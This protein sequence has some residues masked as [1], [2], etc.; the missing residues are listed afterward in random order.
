[1]KEFD[2]M[3]IIKR[4][5]GTIPGEYGLLVKSLVDIK[6][7]SRDKLD[8]VANGYYI[9]FYL[10][11]RAKELKMEDPRTRKELRIDEI[12]ENE[13][14]MGDM[15]ITKDFHDMEAVAELFF[16]DELEKMYPNVSD[17]DVREMLFETEP[18]EDPLEKD[19]FPEKEESAD[20]PGMKGVVLKLIEEANEEQLRLIYFFVAT[21]LD[22]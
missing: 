4:M 15:D 5:Q 2:V 14:M 6:D 10:G 19:F 1:M 22:D 7:N 18:E 9:G 8:A 20:S 16:Y 11:H 17:Q 21:M 13:E 3:N 12:M